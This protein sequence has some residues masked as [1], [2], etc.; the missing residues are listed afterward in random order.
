[1]NPAHLDE[2]TRWAGRV[3]ALRDRF[4]PQA[5]V[6]LGETGNAQCGGEPEISDRFEGGLWWLDQLG[7]L[8]LR[9]QPV[10]VRQTLAGS[11]YGLI[12]D[13]TLSPTPD[14]FNTLLWKRLM[15]KRVLE[16]NRSAHNPYLRLYAH[17]TPSS[18]GKA[19]NVSLL[20]LNMHPTQP[21]EL[22]LEHA[23]LPMTIHELSAPSLSS[24]ELYLGGRRLDASGSLPLLE[25]R[26]S[27]LV[28]GRLVLGP[29]HYVF[30]QLALDAPACRMPWPS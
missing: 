21:A 23:S 25:G 20:A 22:H 8:A 4:A 5:E 16:V 9:G 10:V 13:E 18:D 12:D 26:S 19:G 14:Y 29:T 30:A 28:D 1:L 24:R 2:V 27:E 17:C 6:W 7:A 11:N 3:E 15:G